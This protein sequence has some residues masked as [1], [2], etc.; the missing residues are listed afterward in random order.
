MPGNTSAEWGVYA[1]GANCAS[2]TTS[3]TSAT[4][5]IPNAADGNPARYVRIVATGNAWIKP[6]V[7]SGSTVATGTGILT[8]TQEFLLNVRGYTHIAHI[9]QGSAQT[10]NICPVEV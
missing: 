3:G 1:I 6:V 2:A 10:V 8:G 4:V 9:Q 5:A 7:G